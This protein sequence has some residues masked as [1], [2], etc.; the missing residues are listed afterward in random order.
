MLL[1]ETK[2]ELSVTI[3][4]KDVENTPDKEYND[5][6]EIIGQSLEP[7]SK[8]KKGDQLILY[9]PKIVDKFPDMVEEGWSLADVEAF[10]AKYGIKLEKVEQETSAYNPGTI[11]GQS[12]TKGSTI[13][14]GTTLKV[15]V[16]V[17]PTPKPEPEPEPAQE[18]EP[19]PEKPEENTGEE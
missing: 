5:D 10:C 18:P 19:E 2:Y 11:I 4:K 12:R 1:L 15:T 3:E 9:T 7:G 16:A 6:D 8:V 13:I 14:K 17:K